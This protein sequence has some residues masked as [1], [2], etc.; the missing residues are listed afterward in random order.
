MTYNEIVEKLKIS[1]PVATTEVNAEQMFH[2]YKDRYLKYV[3]YQGNQYEL[4]LVAL[5]EESSKNH[6]YEQIKSFDNFNAF[7]ELVEIFIKNTMKN[8][9]SF[10]IC[11]HKE[12][13]IIME[14]MV[15][16]E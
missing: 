7:T 12:Y 10:L 13:E 11:D 8:K 5:D 4:N 3:D 1:A 9:R 6:V 14:L 16:N 2:L 15:S